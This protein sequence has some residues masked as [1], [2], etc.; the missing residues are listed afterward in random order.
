MPLCWSLCFSAPMPSEANGNWPSS[1][2]T[3]WM[4]APL[5][6]VWTVST[7]GEP[8]GRYDISVAT[9]LLDELDP[10]P[11][12]KTAA[13]SSTMR[14]RRRIQ[15]CPRSAAYRSA[16]RVQSGKMSRYDERRQARAAGLERVPVAVEIERRQAAGGELSLQ[17]GN[18]SVG[19][20]WGE[21]SAVAVRA[22][23]SEHEHLDAR[24]VSDEHHRADLRGDPSQASE[25]IVDTGAVEVL[26]D[27][28]LARG[29]GTSNR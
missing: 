22:N 6:S 7:S 16:G 27:Q 24:V 2:F 29:V 12:M 8:A 15:K 20:R 28:T 25:E 18:V 9:G 1:P 17:G 5:G 14:L 3:P 4:A 13:S 21:H 11:A 23:Q 26:L 10:H 19:R